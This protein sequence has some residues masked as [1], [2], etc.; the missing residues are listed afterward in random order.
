V[1]TKELVDP[2]AVLLVAPEAAHVAVKV[3]AVPPLVDAVKLTV[4][5]MAPATTEVIVGAPGATVAAGVTE[6]LLEEAALV[7]L[8][9][10]AFTEQV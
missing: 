10:V 9:L 3:A 1:T 8:V 4:I 2:V 5:C 7:P 6:V